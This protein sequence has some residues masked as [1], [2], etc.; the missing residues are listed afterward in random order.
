MNGAGG[1]GGHTYCQG[2]ASA[3][4]DYDW[5]EE[6]C[7]GGIHGV[8]TR[9]AFM[10]RARKTRADMWKMHFDTRANTCQFIEGARGF[11]HCLF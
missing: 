5:G 1:L 11:C 3:A 6:V 8:D 10:T 7:R 9:S 4:I 2:K